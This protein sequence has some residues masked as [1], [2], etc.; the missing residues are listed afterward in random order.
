MLSIG[1]SPSSMKC[2]SAAQGR[3]QALDPR[4][5]DQLRQEHSVPILHAIEALL[6]TDRAT[7]HSS[8]TSAH[9]TIAQ[10]PGLVLDHSDHAGLAD[11]LPRPSTHQ[12]GEL[13][14]PQCGVRERCLNEAALIKTT[15]A[16]PDA[17]DAPSSRIRL[18]SL[19]ALGRYLSMYK[20]ISCLTIKKTYAQIIAWYVQCK[21]EAPSSDILSCLLPGRADVHP[22]VFYYGEVYLDATQSAG[23]SMVNLNHA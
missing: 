13:R 17:D 10:Q 4:P 18:L 15:G 2:A 16:Q 9:P 20:Q 5:L 14:P 11:A 21:R 8:R 19:Q 23:F 7:T 3:E 12:R 22:K 1:K 6:L